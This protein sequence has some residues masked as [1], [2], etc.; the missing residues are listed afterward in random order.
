MMCVEIHKT[1][2][3]RDQLVGRIWFDGTR[4]I[5]D[6]PTDPTVIRILNSR[7]NAPDGIVLTALTTPVAWL[8]SLHLKYD[9]AYTR[10]SEVIRDESHAAA[11]QPA[12]G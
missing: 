1:I 2:Q 7:L 11:L 3:G 12:G 4:M 9:N 5:P 10:V 6:P 8:Q